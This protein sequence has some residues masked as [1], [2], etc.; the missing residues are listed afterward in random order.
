MSKKN[1]R[2][3]VFAG[4][5][6]SG[7]TTLYN[8]LVRI[9]AFTPY[10]HINPDQISVDLPVA[11]NLSHWPITFTPEEIIAY[12]DASPFSAKTNTSLS[13]SIIVEDKVI[14]LRNQC[15]EGTSYISAA[16]A[17]FLREK[18]LVSGSSFSYESVFSHTTKVDELAKAKEQGYRIYLYYISTGDPM[19]NK[20]RVQT[21]VELGGHAVPEGKIESRYYNSLKNLYNA[22]LL[23]DRAFFFDNSS[24]IHN[25]S[26]AFFAEKKDDKL[27]TITSELP[28]W[29]DE[30]FLKRQ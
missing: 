13:K 20:N 10:Y 18:L 8:Y 7:K 26:Y 29:F 3:R 25:N 30:Y 19:I 5:N 22:V 14:R 17:A 15:Q 16:L 21:R 24:V 2:L 9:N 12:L 27:F 28:Y 6:G 1:K 23:S 11:V 4:P